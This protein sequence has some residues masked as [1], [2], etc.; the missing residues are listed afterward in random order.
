MPLITIIIVLVLAGVGLYLINKY[1]PMDAKIKTIL[2]VVVILIVI[3]WLLHV[4][5]VWR[6]LESV[7]I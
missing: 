6:Y 5:G 3:I 2:N 7:K 1:V 4:F